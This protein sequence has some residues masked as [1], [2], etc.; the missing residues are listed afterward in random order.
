LVGLLAQLVFY[1]SPFSGR[2][3]FLAQSALNGARLFLVALA[4]MAV[5]GGEVLAPNPSNQ[6]SLQQRSSR[7]RRST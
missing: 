2:R 6:T 7:P 5:L 4:L 3:R 1:S